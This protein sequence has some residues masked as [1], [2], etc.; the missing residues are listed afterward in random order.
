MLVTQSNPTLVAC[1]S[2]VDGYSTL[3]G[4]LVVTIT[5]ND[6]E[7]NGGSVLHLQQML[8]HSM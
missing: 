8:Q 4:V 7:E 5:H 2:E 1:Q 6:Y 3:V